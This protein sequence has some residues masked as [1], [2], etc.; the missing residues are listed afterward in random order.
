MVPNVRKHHPVTKSMLQNF[1][2]LFHAPQPGLK[3]QSLKDSKKT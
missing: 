1:R 2:N 3:F